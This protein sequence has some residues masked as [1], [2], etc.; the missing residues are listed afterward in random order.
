MDW[1]IYLFSDLHLELN[2]SEYV[3]KYI[4]KLDD[5]VIGEDLPSAEH[6]VL[7]LAGDIFHPDVETYKPF[8]DY[9][10]TKFNIILYIF[11]NHEYY[12][13]GHSYLNSK[14]KIRRVLSRYDNLHILDNETYHYKGI[15]FIGTTLWTRITTNPA[16]IEKRGNDYK[17]IYRNNIPIR[18]RDVNRWNEENRIWLQREINEPCIVITHHAPLFNNPRAGVL[19]SDQAHIANGMEEL[20]HNDLR[21]LLNKNIIAWC[22]GHTHYATDFVYEGIQFFSNPLGYRGEQTGF[23]LNA[24]L[25]VSGS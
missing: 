21:Y 15:K 11:G 25:N 4:S 2:G 12:S 23:D 3:M 16:L 20:Y 1:K 7:V 9:I 17:H 5:N 14:H 8:F 6:D 13:H 19:V 22:Y 18:T 24:Y 10:T